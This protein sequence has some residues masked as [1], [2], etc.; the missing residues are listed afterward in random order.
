[1][2]E[3]RTGRYANRRINVRAKGYSQAG[4]SYSKRAL[5]GFR[6]QSGSPREDIDENNDTLRQRSRTMYM[7]SPVAAAAL[8][9]LRTNVVGKG[10]QL[11]STID[12]ET[13][14]MSQEQAELWQKQTEKEFA[15]WA[16]NKKA[17]DAIGMN[18]FYDMQQL[19]MLAWPMSGDVFALCRRYEATRLH[20]YSLRLHIIE[21]D[22]I[23]TPTSSYTYAGSS[24]TGKAEN[25]NTIFDGVEVDSNGKIVAYH[26]SN[27]YP[28]ENTLKANG[29]Q[30]VEAY[31]AETGLPNILHIAETERPEQYR[32]VPYLA[33][34]MEPLLQMRRYTEAE[35]QSAVVQ[36]F[37]TAFVVTKSGTDEMPFNE[38]GE[39]DVS[40]SEND[41]EMGPGTINIMEEGEDVKFATPTHPN[42]GF[43]TFMRALMEQVGA[44]LEIPADMLSMSFNASYSASRAALLEAWK[45]FRMRR[46]WLTQDFCRPTYEIWMTEAVARGRI[47]A[48]G[49]LTDPVMRQA[50]LQSEWIGPPPGQLDPTKEISAAKMAIDEG[51]STREQE[52]IRL[53]GSQYVA[54]VDK[55]V[56]ENAKLQAANGARRNPT[57]TPEEEDKNNEE[58]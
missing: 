40:K 16:D 30:R 56:V 37:L 52:A 46:K 13:L 5:R 21:A 19:V 54:N 49:F 43:E 10:L 4:A 42:T 27:K 12:R 18:D 29:F 51:L 3:Y 34:V 53:N 44:A 9:R 14:G 11:K 58:K 35:I 33:Q 1:M 31:G 25:G 41:Y 23:R 2:P 28:Y 22:R 20:P 32:G 15:L 8:K 24:T 39:D 38:T 50:Y 57:K 36:S 6:A 26:I 17:C 45:G 7:S 47:V 55:L 48:P